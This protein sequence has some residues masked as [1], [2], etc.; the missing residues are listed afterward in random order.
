MAAQKKYVCAF[1]ARAFTRSEHKQRHER[2]HTNEKPFHCLYCTSAFVR[3]DLLQRH[4]RTVH[5][6][7]LVSRSKRDK[8]A[9]SD[10][11]IKSEQQDPPQLPPAGPPSTTMPPINGERVFHA[12]PLAPPLAHVP[13]NAEPISPN[14]SKS[15]NGPI[16][17][18][19]TPVINPHG[20]GMLSPNST[21]PLS[22]LRLSHA[23][24]AQDPL[25]LLSI[26]KNLTHIY[27]SSD[28]RY[29]VHDLFLV[30]HSVLSSERYSVFPNSLALLVD[31]L[32]SHLSGS[33]LSEF[34]L[35]QVYSIL[36]VGALSMP[37]KEFDPEE[38]ATS[39]INKSW[40]IVVDKLNSA[41]SSLSVQCDVLK[42]L[43]LL[44]YI[45]LRFFNNDLMVSYLEDSAHII[46]QNLSASP[47]D[48][49]LISSNLELFWS[50]Y[51]LV[52]KY[53]A[54]EAP[55]KLYS[56]FLAS[57]LQKDS[58][59]TLAQAVKTY[60][61]Q[62]LPLED[63]F[64]LEVV[65]CTLSN[66]VNNLV[67]NKTLWLFESLDSLHNAIVL[68]NKSMVLSSA[69]PNDGMDI[70]NIFRSKLIL[71]ASP[72]YEELLQAHVFK[73][74]APQ[75]WNMLLLTLRE[76]NAPFSFNNFMR[77][78]LMSSFQ[79]FGNSLLGF[80]TFESSNMTSSHGHSSSPEVHKNLGI[81]SFP[82]IFQYNFLR[83]NNVE[84]PFK[85]KDLSIVDLANLNNL[86]LE[87][88]ITIVK[89]LVN[90]ITKRSAAEAEDI[91]RNSNVLSCLFYM[92]NSNCTSTPAF[93]STEFYLQVFEELTKICDTWFNFIN[94]STNLRNLR[95]NLN[96]FLNDLVV[97]A[98]NNEN[99]S[100]SDL[101][102]ANESILIRNRRSKSI[103]SIDMSSTSSN[104]SSLSTSFPPQVPPQRGGSTNYV[105][106]NKPENE[107]GSPQPMYA[108]QMSP[109]SSL[110]PLQGVTKLKFSSPAGPRVQKP[111]TQPMNSPPVPPSSTYVLP[112]IYAAVKD[113]AK[114][115]EGM[116]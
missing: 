75:H 54:N 83:L 101:Y 14:S 103:G 30:G 71:G 15:P 107:A 67:F 73:I 79:N 31:Q 25:H 102:V 29:P 94:Q 98:L 99:I 32:H 50:I 91:V 4:C 38:L 16:V 96:R 92:I 58:S 60:A 42:N 109:S 72:T 9:L 84:P 27:D 43:F 22:S 10:G 18:G 26:S 61:K 95:M 100:L 116:K 63:Q 34:R 24:V 56:W 110:A 76:F 62:S 57:K 37:S 77:E 82:L 88:Y 104:R 6:I 51:V 114:P 23:S 28:L 11:S 33:A 66:E 40:N 86:I 8:R 74:S 21:A 17:G 59:I 19:Q 52:S 48:S 3:R 39:F 20:P 44:T 97:L 105:L 111:A 70:F 7:K 108:S 13:A 49:E 36:A 85:P 80:F 87:W 81:I 78:N 41:H 55:P 89:V 2:S 93:A 68:A 35:G 46:L 90:L 53:K 45:Y 65:I 64:L 115:G 5:N 47:A 113:H 112:P 69:S 106:M 12:P 1:C